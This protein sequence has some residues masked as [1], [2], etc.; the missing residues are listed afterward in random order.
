MLLLQPTL[1]LRSGDP[2]AVHVLERSRL[3]P[4]AHTAASCDI[5]PTTVSGAQGGA[6]G[7]C[8]WARTDVGVGS[9]IREGRGEQ[10][11]WISLPGPP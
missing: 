9:H 10:D 8:P 3:G 6:S 2:M 11:P 7:S 5:H 1:Q 4:G